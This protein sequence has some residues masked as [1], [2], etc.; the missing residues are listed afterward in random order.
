MGITIV[1]L[2]LVAGTTGLGQR[3][4]ESGEGRVSRRCVVGLTK[5]TPFNLII[6]IRK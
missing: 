3:R 1:D 4:G 5:M 6:R 2:R